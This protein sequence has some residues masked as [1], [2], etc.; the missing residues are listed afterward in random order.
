[1][2]GRGETLLTKA[3]NPTNI[4]ERNWTA[5]MDLTGTTMEQEGMTQR[6]V[7][8]PRFL[9]TDFLIFTFTVTFVRN[10]Q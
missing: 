2:A 3:S 6:I 9:S 10:S 1:M 7:S 4:M 8:S 5:C